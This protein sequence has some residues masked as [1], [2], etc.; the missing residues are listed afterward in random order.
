MF[1]QGFVK[2]A[3]P[4]FVLKFKKKGGASMNEFEKIY[5]SEKNEKTAFILMLSVISEKLNEVIDLLA[6][7]N[8]QLISIGKDLKTLNNKRLELQ[9]DKSY[10]PLTSAD[11]D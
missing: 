3:S 8:K 2:Y 5:T 1:C 11:Y 4:F 9:E 7:N 10:L 6:Q